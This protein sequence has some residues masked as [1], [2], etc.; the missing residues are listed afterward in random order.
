MAGKGIGIT[1][2]RAVTERCLDY[3]SLKVISSSKT[4]EDI[5]CG[6]LVSAAG[7][8]AGYLTKN[9]GIDLPIEPRKRCVYVFDCPGAPAR[10]TMPFV[11][12]SSGVYVRNEGGRLICGGPIENVSLDK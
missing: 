9:L 10:E 8:S 5:H 3:F 2:R 7:P 4:V 11:I 1:G 12:D 6:V